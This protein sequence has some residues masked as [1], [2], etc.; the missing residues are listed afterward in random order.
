MRH[1]LAILAT[2]ALALAAPV[3]Y[4]YGPDFSRDVEDAARN[5]A[6]LA[7]AVATSVINAE[8]AQSP[9]GT[10]G[11]A[12]PAAASLGALKEMNASEKTP[13]AAKPK[14]AA[15]AKPKKP[16][17]KSSRSQN[18]ASVA[19]KTPAA[20]I[21]RDSRVPTPATVQ[22]DPRD[23]RWIKGL[24]GR[25]VRFTA[26]KDAR[27]NPCARLGACEDSNVRPD[28]VSV[29][30]IVVDSERLQRIEAPADAAG[31]ID[32]RVRRGHWAEKTPAVYVE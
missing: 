32:G 19:P 5:K 25:N 13:A 31:M 23:S 12:S 22:A 7:S 30:G 29:V 26:S 28:S 4:Q 17:S 1:G 2:A 6:A 21:L 11:K 9:A 24:S 10:Q 8:A 18:G 15:S 20:E 27:D 16:A 3:I 14:S